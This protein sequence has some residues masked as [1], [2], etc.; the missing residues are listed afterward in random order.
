MMGEIGR[1]L[2]LGYSLPRLIRHHDLLLDHRPELGAMLVDELSVPLL[3]RL[4]VFIQCV[5]T[6]RGVH[7]P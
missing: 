6:R 2:L 4:Q 5:N 1:E 3:H 7:P